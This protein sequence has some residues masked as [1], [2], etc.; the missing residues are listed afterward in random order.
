[1]MNESPKNFVAR[2]FP[3]FLNS[4][5]QTTRQFNDRMPWW[6][7]HSNSSW[8]L[9]PSIYHK[10][11]KNNESNMS[12]QFR[13]QA[14][15]RHQDVPELNDGP[16]WVFLMQHYGL[17][18]RLLDW[19]D[20][21]LIALNFAISDSNY[22][23]KSATV[24]GLMPTELNE[25]QVGVNGIIGIG[26]QTALKSFA[27]VWKR[28]AERIE[29]SEVIAINTQHIDVRQMVQA[30][31]FTIH[32]FETDMAELP[33]AQKFLCS[34]TIPA[35]SKKHFRQVLNLFHITESYLFPDL[36]HLARQIQSMP[37]TSTDKINDEQA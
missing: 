27:N 12:V 3:E 28:P 20:S 29:A 2:D 26:N 32:G 8:K 1:M 10:N 16:S 11:L 5:A 15:V 36:E 34:I 14:R 17:P 22:D 13:N 30:S 37:Y 24:W 6:R 31:Q 23:N 21:P 9:H 7:G 4:I 33:D 35:A 18:T 25:K 19:S